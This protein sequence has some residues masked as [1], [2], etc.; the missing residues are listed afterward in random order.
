MAHSLLARPWLSGLAAITFA[1]L[2]ASTAPA[3]A[4]SLFGLFSFDVTPSEVAANINRHGY[5]IRS[6]IHPTR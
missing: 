4:E 5:I 6:A 3:H 1:G 2:A